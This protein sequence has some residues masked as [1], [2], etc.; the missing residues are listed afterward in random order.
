MVE[1][2]QAGRR[3]T[4]LERTHKALQ[5]RMDDHACHHHRSLWQKGMS[6][7]LVKRELSCTLSELEESDSK[8]ERTAESGREREGERERGRWRGRPAEERRI[9]DPRTTLFVG[10]ATQRLDNERVLR[11]T[12]Q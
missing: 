7:K 10:R 4:A 6:A 12:R 5:S 8:Q 11:K 1:Y 2:L 3:G 9:P